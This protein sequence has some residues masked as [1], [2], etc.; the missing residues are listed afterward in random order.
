LI[1]YFTGINHLDR[2]GIEPES[3]FIPVQ[4]I[5]CKDLFVAM[6]V[7]RHGITAVVPH[8]GVVHGPDVVRPA[9]FVDH[10]LGHWVQTLVK[11]KGGKVGLRGDAMVNDSIFI[12]NLYAH[13]LA[14][15]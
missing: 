2:N 11:R 3:I 9:E 12:R 4:G 15:P 1:G 10:G 5:F 13:H 7:G 8:I 14:E 6:Y